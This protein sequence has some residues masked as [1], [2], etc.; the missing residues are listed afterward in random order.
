MVD[1]V[2]TLGDL[3]IT[4]NEQGLAIQRAGKI[5]V[6]AAVDRSTSQGE[7]GLFVPDAGY[8]FGPIPDWLFEERAPWPTWYTAFRDQHATVYPFRGGDTLDRQTGR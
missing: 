1:G 2:L 4:S 7:V 6:E 5:I 3:Q 8:P